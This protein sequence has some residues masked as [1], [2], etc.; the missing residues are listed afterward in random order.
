MSAPGARSVAPRPGRRSA[1]RA[2]GAGEC[3]TPPHRGPLEPAGRAVATPRVP[4]GA[5]WGAD[6]RPQTVQPHHARPIL[7]PRVQSDPAGSA[8]TAG[9][10]G[11]LCPLWTGCN[12]RS[13]PYKICK[14]RTFH[15]IG[16]QV[17]ASVC[18]R[19]VHILGRRAAWTT[20]QQT[21]A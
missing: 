5:W 6:L 16:G 7:G 21:D 2:T 4:G 20:R 19:V 9:R 14:E 12:E 15:Y 3:R 13:F 18:W 11:P 17:V 8:F 10:G 1:Q